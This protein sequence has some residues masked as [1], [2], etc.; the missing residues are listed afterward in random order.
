MVGNQ[1]N[2]I[3]WQWMQ[4][5][6]NQ[7]KTNKQNKKKT[8]T[9]LRPSFKRLEQII[10]NGISEHTAFLYNAEDCENGKGESQNRK[11]KLG[12]NR[13]ASI[14]TIP[15]LSRVGEGTIKSVVQSGTVGWQWQLQKISWMVD[16]F[17][18]DSEVMF[19]KLQKKNLYCRK[20]YIFNIIHLQI[21]CLHG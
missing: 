10:R 16:F 15:G 2:E 8:C 4:K 1:W 21:Q 7:Y 19:S 12:K 14:Y 17:L 3:P 11:K 9:Q 18:G 13:K 20:Q 5:I 6:S